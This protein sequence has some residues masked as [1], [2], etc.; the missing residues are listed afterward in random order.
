MFF[1][2]ELPEI[3]DS[4]EMDVSNLY[5]E[6]GVTDHTLLP[7]TELRQPGDG[8]LIPMGNYK[9][10]LNAYIVYEDKEKTPK[11][12]LPGATGRGPIPDLNEFMS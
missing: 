6:S 10:V 9:D 12:E 3:I 7:K 1:Y 2:D 11:F 5:E 8:K 4:P